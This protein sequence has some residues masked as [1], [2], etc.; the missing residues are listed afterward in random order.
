MLRRY[1]QLVPYR[2]RPAFFYESFY[3]IGRGCFIALW[4]FSWVVLK[5][6]LGGELWHLAAIRFALGIG[7]SGG[8]GLGPDWAAG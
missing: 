1:L 7:G 4:P 3:S 2:S 5:T 6:E 8:A